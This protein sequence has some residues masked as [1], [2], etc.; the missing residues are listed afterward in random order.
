MKAAIVQQA[1]KLP[2][3][4]DFAEPTVLEGENRIAVTAADP[5]ALK[6]SANATVGGSATAL[7]VTKPGTNSTYILPSAGAFL[8]TT[9][10]SASAQ[11]PLTAKSVR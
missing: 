4:A 11:K 6:I 8:V 5:L 2:V 10:S 7:V 9:A 3:Y 1:G